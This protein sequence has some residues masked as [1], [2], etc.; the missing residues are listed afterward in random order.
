MWAIRLGR[1]GGA[2]FL[3]C[4]APVAD[5]QTAPAAPPAA[6]PAAVFA[7]KPAFS[8]PKL[9][10]DAARVAAVEHNGV[11]TRL[12]ITALTGQGGGAAIL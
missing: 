10:P 6:I 5:A 3:F 2:A 7:E 9:S 12:L 1:I 11:K 8:L 4:C